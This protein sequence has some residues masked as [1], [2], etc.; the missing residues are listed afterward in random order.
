M[1]CGKGERRDTSRDLCRMEGQLLVGLTPL[2]D[3]G[4]QN[5]T[6]DVRTTNGVNAT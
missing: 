1:V 6:Y 4:D 5:S 2:M 3:L